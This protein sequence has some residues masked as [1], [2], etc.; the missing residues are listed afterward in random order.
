VHACTVMR[1]GLERKPGDAPMSSKSRGRMAASVGIKHGCRRDTTNSKFEYRERAAEGQPGTGAWTALAT[2][3]VGTSGSVDIR[4]LAGGKKYEFRITSE[5]AENATVT[6]GAGNLTT[7][8]FG[9]GIP[10]PP[11]VSSTTPPAVTALAVIGQELTWNAI[12]GTTVKV[13]G[14]YKGSHVWDSLDILVS[15][16]SGGKMRL[17]MGGVQPGDYEVRISHYSGDTLVAFEARSVEVFPNPSAAP[18]FV[19]L[20]RGRAIE[21]FTLADGTLT[22]TRPAFAAPGTARFEFSDAANPNDPPH[23]REVVSTG[24]TDG[25]TLAGLPA[26]MHFK[27]TYKEDGVVIGGGAA[28]IMPGSAADVVAVAIGGIGVSDGRLRWNAPGKDQT[29]RVFMRVDGVFTRLPDPTLANGQYSIAVP[30]RTE[31]FESYEYLIQY[32]DKNGQ[33]IALGAAR[34]ELSP[35]NLRGDHVLFAPNNAG[36]TNITADRQTISWDVRPGTPR[37][38][39]RVLGSGAEWESLELAA[40]VPGVKRESV[41][42][43]GLNGKFE[44]RITYTDPT[45]DGGVSD[46]ASGTL[47]I[48]SPEPEL[49]KLNSGQL[50]GV[51]TVPGGISWLKPAGTTRLSILV[52]NPESGAWDPLP[53]ELISEQ[54]TRQVIDLSQVDAGS[55]QVLI[56]YFTGSE[57]SHVLRGTVTTFA[58]GTATARDTAVA[59]FQPTANDFSW[60]DI[61]GAGTPF[62][63]YRL[64]ADGNASWRGDLPVGAPVDGKRHVNISSLD[65]N[66]EYR[67][68]YTSGAVVMAL[69][70]GHLDIVRPK[71]QLSSTDGAVLKNM[72]TTATRWSWDTPA[73][74][75]TIKFRSLGGQWSVPVPVKTEGGRDFYDVVDAP[76]GTFEYAITYTEEAFETAFSTG[77]VVVNPP[78]LASADRADILGLTQGPSSLSWTPNTTPDTTAKFVYRGSSDLAGPWSSL[79][80]LVVDGKATVDLTGLH[81]SYDYRISYERN[82]D[83]SLVALDA[84]RFDVT[85]TAPTLPS[86]GASKLQGLTATASQLKWVA[87]TGTLKVEYRDT[88]G[89]FANVGSEFLARNVG[90]YDAVDLSRFGAIAGEFRIT[91]TDGAGLVTAMAIGDIS[92]PGWS[93]P[94]PNAAAN[95]TGAKLSGLTLSWTSTHTGTPQFFYRVSGGSW[96]SGPQPSG[97]SVSIAS[98]VNTT[99]VYEYRIVY[100]DG[101]GMTALGMGKLTTTVATASLGGNSGG[102]VEGF[103]IDRKKV[104]W[105][106]PSGASGAPVV[107]VRKPGFAWEG[108]QDVSPNAFDLSQF[109][110][111]GAYE[112][113]VAYSSGGQVTHLGI[114]SFTVNSPTVSG[115][116]SSDITGVTSAAGPRLVWNAMSVGTPLLEY[117]DGARGAWRSAAADGLGTLVANDGTGRASFNF[118]Q[119]SGGPYQYRITYMQGLD[120]KALARGQITFNGGSAAP[121]I[122]PVATAFGASIVA[123]LGELRWTP[124]AGMSAGLGLVA[125]RVAGGSSTWI[126]GGAVQQRGSIH[127]VDIS[128]IGAGNYEFRIH[129][130]SGVDTLAGATPTVQV[131]AAPATV[132]QALSSLGSFILTGTQLSW[133]APASGGSPV[134]EYQSGSSWLG[135]P[136]VGTFNGKPSVNIQGLYGVPVNFRVRYTAG[137][138]DVGFGSGSFNASPATQSHQLLASDVSGYRI[139][140]GKLLWNRPASASGSAT[141]SWRPST[142]GGWQSVA[143]AESFDLASLASGTWEYRVTYSSGGVETYFGSGALKVPTGVSL[144][145]T[146]KADIG[147]VTAPPNGTTLQ[148]APSA[149]AGATPTFKYLHNG[150][151]LSRAVS[152]VNG[153]DSVSVRG[154]SGTRQ[155]RIEYTLNGQIVGLLTGSFTAGST[156]TPVALDTSRGEVEGVSMVGTTLGWTRPPAGGTA[157]VY[158]RR[159]GQTPWEEKGVSGETAN[160]AGITNDQYEFRIVYTDANK[161]VTAMAVGTLLPQAVQVLPAATTNVGGFQVTRTRLS[162]DKPALTG[163]TEH[164]EYYEAGELHSRQVIDDAGGRRAIDITGLEAVIYRYR[165]VYRDTLTGDIRALGIGTFS[166]GAQA[167]P[168]LTPVVSTISQPVLQ[169]GRLVWERPASVPAGSAA[170]FERKLANGSWYGF[171]IPVTAQDATHD[172]IELSK[173]PAGT[174]EWRVKY[175]TSSGVVMGIGAGT[176]V[177]PPSVALS[178]ETLG[179]VTGIRSDAMWLSWDPMDA[180]L[181]GDVLAE[182]YNTDTNEWDDALVELV[183]GRPA[184]KIAGVIGTYDF[185]ISYGK[186]IDGE[187]QVMALGRGQFTGTAGTASH[188]VQESTVGDFKVVGNELSWIPTAGSAEV[189][190]LREGT[191][192]WELISPVNANGSRH[193]VIIGD[194]EAGNYQYRVVYKEG[195]VVTGM[196]RIGVTIDVGIV[197][198]RRPAEVKEA[199]RTITNFTVPAQTHD[200]RWTRDAGGGTAVFEYRR[201]GTA[202]WLFAPVGSFGAQDGVDVRSLN[203]TQGGYE[204]RVHYRSGQGP[205]TVVSANGAGKFTVPVPLAGTQKPT[206]QLNTAPVVLSNIAATPNSVT[207]NAPPDSSGHRVYVETRL[208][209]DTVWAGPVN[210]TRGGTTDGAHFDIVAYASTYEFRITYTDGAGV[211]TAIGSAVVKFGD[212][213]VLRTEPTSEITTPPYLAYRAAAD[214]KYELK[215]TTDS[216]PHAISDPRLGFTAEHTPGNKPGAYALQPKIVQTLDRWGNVI[217]TTDPRNA[218][219]KTTYKWN[220]ANQLVEQVRP[221]DGS[222]ASPTT[223]IYYDAL[224]RQIGVQDAEGVQKGNKDYL[225]TKTYDQAGNVIEEGQADGGRITHRYD[226]LG[227]KVQTTDAVGNEAQR[228]G[229]EWAEWERETAEEVEARRLGRTTDFS[230][231]RMG[232]LTKAEHGKV[233]VYSMS[234]GSGVHPTM[235]LSAP[236]WRRVSETFTYDEAGRRISQTDGNYNANSDPTGK[237]REAVMTSYKYDAAARVVE[238]RQPKGVKTSTTYDA[239]GFKQSETDANGKTQTWQNDAFG[240]VLSHTDLAGVTVDYDYD[241]A[242]LL[243]SM[244]TRENG[245]VHTAGSTPVPGQ[246]QEFK[247]DQ[248]GQLL[249][250]NDTGVGRTTTY[251]YDAAG[252]RVLE[253]TEQDVDGRKLLLQDN[254]LGYDAQ[255]RLRQIFDGHLSIAIDYDLNGNR[256]KITTGISVLSAAG[257]SQETVH[258]SVRNFE[259]DAMNRQTVVEEYDEKRLAVDGRMPGIVRHDIKYYLDGTRRSDEFFGNRVVATGGET[260]TITEERESG[261]FTYDAMTPITYKREQGKVTEK[262]RYDNLGRLMSVVR[263]DTQVDLRRYDGVGRALQSGSPGNLPTDYA[264]TLN[265]GVPQDQQI[266][267]DQRFS[268]Y[269]ENGRLLLQNV[270]GSDGTFKQGV[271]YINRGDGM[272]YDAAGN[273]KGYK[274]NLADHGF[275]ETHR[276]QQAQFGGYVVASET[277]TDKDDKNAT[278]AT[279]EYDANGHQK[280]IVDGGM[281]ANNRNIYSDAAGRALLVDQGGKLHRQLIVNGEVLGSHGIGLDDLRPKDDKKAPRF[282]PHVDF[283]W[284]YQQINGHHPGAS[285]GAYTVRQGDTLQGIARGAYGDSRMWYRIAEANGLSSDSDLRIGQTLIIPTG[286]GGVHN[287]SDTFEPYDPRKVVGD[288]SPT[289]PIPAGQDGRCGALSKV[290]GLVVSAV[291]T[292]FT[293]GNVALGAMA[294]DAA[295]QVSYA[296]LNGQFDW[297]DFA[298][299]AHPAMLGWQTDPKH[300]PGFKDIEYDYKATAVAGASAYVTQYVGVGGYSSNPYVNAAVQQAVNNVASQAIGIAIGAQDRFQWK[301]VVAAAAGGAVG[302][303]VGGTFNDAFGKIGGQFATGLV[304]GTVVAV[305]RG[306][307]ISFEQIATDAFGNAL[308]NAVVDSMQPGISYSAEEMAG[309]YARENNRFASAA[310]LN[311]SAGGSGYTGGRAFAA[312]V[313]RRRELISMGLN[314]DDVGDVADG[315]ARMGQRTIDPRRA[316]ARVEGR[317]STRM[318]TDTP[319]GV[320]GTLDDAMRDLADARF[321]GAL[322]DRYILTAAQAASVG[323]VQQQYG[324]V[325]WG[326]DTYRRDLSAFSSGLSGLGDEIVRLHALTNIA[327]SRNPGYQIDGDVSIGAMPVLLGRDMSLLG[328]PSRVLGGMQAVLNGPVGY[329]DDGNPLFL[330]PRTYSYQGQE[331]IA[332]E[333]AGLGMTPTAGARG[334]GVARSGLTFGA[335]ATERLASTL[336]RVEADSLR[337]PGSGDEL[338]TVISPQTG[339]VVAQVV[340]AGGRGRPPESF[341]KAMDGSVFTHNHP[342]GSSLGFEDVATALAQGARQVRAVGDKN[343]YVLDINLPPVSQSPARA[344]FATEVT[345]AQPEVQ[346]SVVSSTPGF[347]GLPKADRIG[348]FS[349]ALTDYWTNLGTR[350]PDYFRFTV[351]PTKR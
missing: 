61:P 135:G 279:T 288:T 233:N 94:T 36:I 292:Y 142:G 298:K 290:I 48:T 272:G 326:N 50:T 105:A 235:T 239:F 346:R 206:L 86:Q 338:L 110:V 223:R 87:T 277:T 339:E 215:P 255:G 119:L 143:A 285:P 67:V 129:Y 163:V 267:M 40:R 13:E 132:N 311:A 133:T 38:E 205:Y 203:L 238:V 261:E 208:V 164:F 192:D 335:G 53:W 222:G 76:V 83:H 128:G 304:T 234:L 307:R 284:G 227:N 19:D 305:A 74:I 59:V 125:Y 330:N 321:A 160:L 43:A 295:R 263:D 251:R 41:S 72:D 138:Y 318:A 78:T 226:A 89:E 29:T 220:W 96:L 63:Q 286:V 242:Q 187:R 154:L 37:F 329:G 33:E 218:Q 344:N 183:G 139:E 181:V 186:M 18:Y 27:V 210:V 316:L 157:K 190:R 196:A 99:A 115:H 14:R 7:Y 333:V 247:Y 314:P 244:K 236:D 319:A 120:T 258:N 39:G 121:S 109:G 3:R 150:N 221:V 254:H 241:N 256:K 289:L 148:W 297:K 46:L 327:Q 57:V 243:Q 77:I 230:Y 146:T 100:A 313:Q 162:W 250:I 259:Y 101:A 276:F 262:Y 62:F 155:F 111:S 11:Q 152:R 325:R 1:R 12:A 268:A 21:K 93:I 324:A 342:S 56:T 170:L 173:L 141:F 283:E 92:G 249:E 147:P 191:T 71:P 131:H 73:G 172:G 80:I 68:S 204:F 31:G 16:S 66:Y 171:D 104:S 178:N 246:K 310:A 75:G 81:G 334:V 58:P 301:A 341:L 122:Q 42:I 20:T 189:H 214:A 340:H 309:D 174:H 347:F 98:L 176:L 317:L 180:A 199:T 34:V 166:V 211:V 24:A 225:N 212:A 200:I 49:T 145:V 228:T 127:F 69:A 177:V 116:T 52:L 217:E 291:V 151:W 271:D 195:G 252:N 348:A 22:W 281:P 280:R 322:R 134:F 149:F 201:Q 216:T 91:Y 112:V 60:T 320:R 337:L 28:T 323:A 153:Q 336:A 10:Q 303:T 184:V 103:Q 107:H 2:T 224:G 108:P 165:V 275:I 219:W 168:V 331:E 287:A 106:T 113:R 202:E 351:S 55:N 159:S 17:D 274:V 343:T 302:Q 25:I 175:T 232:R 64:R 137:G 299:R 315:A 114:A 70:T 140:F 308:G 144:P 169:S 194:I 198:E 45:T 296:M 278:A 44:W 300:P 65:G 167:T 188:T 328:I 161:V 269:D 294:G 158:V 264:K 30:L 88:G 136:V 245:V 23:V 35:A 209:D 193:N 123:G 185:R 332:F 182:V 306:G 266:G 102:K 350:Y 124:P 257:A 229:A 82:D 117:F 90:G 312:D 293:F 270:H 15:P 248:A 156:G 197:A 118:I 32:C 95:V 47:D 5:E 231:D 84:G 126:P 207:W 26:A 253:R 240:R 237:I 97:S 85:T 51:V 54:G 6:I 8:A 213:N 260:V 273:L 130:A 4:G 79:D 179:N 9:S 349:N 265:E 282:A 345:M